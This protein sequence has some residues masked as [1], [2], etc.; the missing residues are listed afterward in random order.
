MPSASK[1]D[2]GPQMEHVG[3]GALALPGQLRAQQ[4]RGRGRGRRR[5]CGG[6]ATGREHC[7]HVQRGRPHRRCAWHCVRSAR[8]ACTG[9]W[10]PSKTAGA[11]CSRAPVKA[12]HA[13][14]G[15]RRRGREPGAERAVARE[16]EPGGGGEGQLGVVGVAQVHYGL[17]SKVGGPAR[18]AAARR[19]QEAGLRQ[20]SWLGGGA[21][22]CRGSRRA[23]GKR[24]AASA[25]LG[26]HAG[27][28]AT[29]LAQPRITQGSPGVPRPESPM[30][31]TRPASRTRRQT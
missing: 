23:R 30:M 11:R 19:G 5:K 2:P 12:L 29:P 10:T 4:E 8:A 7:W 14:R 1:S 17:E 27:V 9:R 3:S 26:T 6:A 24:A 16:R 25:A 20:G 22:E 13:E 31:C 28:T 21:L 18:R 15:R